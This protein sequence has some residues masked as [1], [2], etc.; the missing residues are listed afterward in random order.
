M[1]GDNKLYKEKISIA[2]VPFKGKWR[3]CIAEN[4]KSITENLNS[5]R[6]G[7]NITSTSITTQFPCYV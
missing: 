2:S 4:L 6:I 7:E 3:R 5:D 1:N